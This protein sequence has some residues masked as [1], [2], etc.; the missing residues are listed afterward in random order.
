MPS[1]LSRLPARRSRARIRA[2]T[3]RDEIDRH[4]ADADRALAL[5]DAFEAAGE[6]L[7]AV[8][9]LT[10]SNRLRPEGGL[11]HRLV[12]L[13]RRA[14]AELRRLQP[15]PP[16][17]PAVD[18]A[19]CGPGEGPP[20]VTPDEL[21]PELLRWGILR[22]GCV[23]VRHLV[24]SARVARLRAAIDRAFEARD[25]RPSGRTGADAARWYAPV[26][27]VRK[28]ASREWVRQGQ[29]VL[30]ADS[31]GAFFELLE[32]IY[33]V[34]LDRV[35]EGYFAERPA[36]SVEKTTLRRADA[37]LHESMWHQDGA[38]LGSGIRSVD[39]WFALSR[40]GRDAPGLDLI[41]VRLERVLPTG[42]PGTYFQWTVSPD[43]I[44]RELP[45]ARV[46][47]PVFEEGDTL[48][49]DHLLLH[50]TAADPHMPGVRYAIESWFFAPSVDPKASTPLAI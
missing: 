49:F 14:F 39:A 5:G 24:P 50:R 16:W 11:E 30:A 47:R 6:L 38:F 19:R 32:T 9:A 13:R 23:L 48:L 12:R 15:P 1:F 7:E 2:A 43:T 37:S 29:G 46:W 27:R 10:E 21:T 40:C 4:G 41:P 28:D 31:P 20:V 26:E 25:G 42:E 22:R 8:A 45:E 18:G 35:I 33:E 3:L 34:G 36:L 44:A 17:P